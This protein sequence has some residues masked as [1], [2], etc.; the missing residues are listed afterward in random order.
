MRGI[1][2]FP[3]VIDDVEVPITATASDPASSD[4]PVET[5]ERLRI[6]A[7]VRHESTVV[8]NGSQ[9]AYLNS[10]GLAVV[11]GAIASPMGETCEYVLKGITDP[12]VVLQPSD[13]PL[14]FSLA[15]ATA[16]WACAFNPLTIFQEDWAGGAKKF[17]ETNMF[18][19]FNY[20]HRPPSRGLFS[21]DGPRP[22]PFKAPITYFEGDYFSDVVGAMTQAVAQ[23]LIREGTTVSVQLAE[24]S[25]LRNLDALTGRLDVWAMHMRIDVTAPS[26]QTKR[27]D[28]LLQNRYIADVHL[29]PPDGWARANAT[30][31][32]Q[33][34]QARL[35]DL[36][37][38]V[39]SGDY[40]LF[41]DSDPGK[42][43]TN[44][45]VNPPSEGRG[46]TSKSGVL[47]QTV[48]LVAPLRF[49]H[50]ADT[51]VVVIKGPGAATPPAAPVVM[52]AD[53]LATTRKYPFRWSTGLTPASHYQ[54]EVARDTLFADLV[55][56]GADI[57]VQEFEYQPTEDNETL[58]WRVRGVNTLGEGPW[59]RRGRV[60]VIDAIATSAEDPELPDAL[61]LAVYPNPVSQRATVAVEVPTPGRVQL[62]LF[63]ALGRRVA[64]VTDGDR[65]AGRYEASVDVS[66]LPAGLY[67]LRADVGGEVALHPLTV[68]R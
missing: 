43:E 19:Q 5:E 25:W 56:S 39:D 37:D 35:R 28:S 14:L 44:Q 66:G 27:F 22:G 63:D 40:L 23:D 46:G 61:A 51:R 33:E 48:D 7:N 36:A 59:S 55:A 54:I 13:S 58:Y 10:S 53:T 60:E 57:Q 64:R 24:V 62:A 16:E 29:L 15:N 50:A 30:L 4:A 45:A 41:L 52:S 49:D 32:A 6:R 34:E 68:V 11:G 67:V 1:Y 17:G 42:T 12:S 26:G 65:P 21:V 2:S 47:E 9:S 38:R 20:L 3:G 18:L 31:R 8:L